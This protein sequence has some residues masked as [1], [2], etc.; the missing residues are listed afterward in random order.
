M[1]LIFPFCLICTKQKWN[2]NGK[3]SQQKPERKNM[4]YPI[5]YIYKVKFNDPNICVSLKNQNILIET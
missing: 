1:T 5:T 2:K 4:L 3:F